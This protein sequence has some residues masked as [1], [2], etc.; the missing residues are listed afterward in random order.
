MLSFQVTPDGRSVV[1]LA[2]ALEDGRPEFFRAPLD[3]RTPPVALDPAPT[4]EEVTNWW[5]APDGAHLVH[6]RRQRMLPLD[7]YIERL[8]VL[9]VGAGSARVELAVSRSDRGYFG[10]SFPPWSSRP[11]AGKPSMA[12][13][14][15]E[16]TEARRPTSSRGR[17]TRVNRR[18]R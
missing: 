4:R 12:I 13:A 7:N 15:T 18:S 16:R 11:M 5:L 9:A 3:G 8:F 6:T 10:S 17:S 2:D 1:Y 14:S